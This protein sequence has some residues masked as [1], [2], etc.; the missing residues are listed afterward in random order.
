MAR[1][2]YN[3]SSIGGV[4]I[5]EAIDEL[6]ELEAKLTRIVALMN[7]I[8]ASGVTPVNLEGSTEFG[9]A[10]GSGSDFYTAVNNIKTTVNA[11]TVAS[12]ASLDKGAV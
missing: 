5:A 8:T 4:M 3:E 10:V 7:E 11:V 1:I 2:E 6:S 12:I 9:V